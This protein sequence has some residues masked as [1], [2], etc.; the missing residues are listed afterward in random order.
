MPALPAFT[1]REVERLTGLSPRRLQYWD[2]TNF[3]RPSVAARQGRG[4]P[5][6]YSF[7]DLVQL[8]VAAMLRDGLSLQALRRLKVALDVD[9]PFASVR[10]AW[11][12][13]SLEVVYLGPSGQLEAARWPGQIVATFDVPLEQI[14]ADLQTSIRNLRTRI[15]F[16]KVTATRG[17]LAGRPAMVG[18]RISPQAV[19][20][21]FRG[22]WSVEDI[23]REY[24]ELT[25]ADVAAAKRYG[26]RQRR[27]G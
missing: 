22:G 5:R 12:P 10:F 18:T 14:R 2:E 16:G 8:K 26:Q 1:T 17:V 27:A 24:P 21:M 13:S 6:L 7:R 11:L 20:R 15:S 25:P 23:I 3:I 9:A 19:K 4:A